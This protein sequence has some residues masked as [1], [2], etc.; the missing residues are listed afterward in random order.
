MIDGS[1]PVFTKEGLNFDNECTSVWH[2]MTWLAKFCRYETWEFSL[3]SFCRYNVKLNKYGVSPCS[4]SAY[5]EMQESHVL[6]ASSVRLTLQPKWEGPLCLHPAWAKSFLFRW[7]VVRISSSGKSKVGSRTKISEAGSSGASL[8]KSCPQLMQAS[9]VKWRLNPIAMIPEANV[10]SQKDN[11][12]FDWYLCLQVLSLHAR[13]ANWGW[14]AANWPLGG[15]C[16]LRSPPS[17]QIKSP[18]FP[19]SPVKILMTMSFVRL[20]R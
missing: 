4:F 8:L 15:C 12:H 1:I 9:G 14:Q 10:Y 7:K 20:H 19:F 6:H 16:R 13:Q 5:V 18:L 11:A 17:P 3:L 2:D